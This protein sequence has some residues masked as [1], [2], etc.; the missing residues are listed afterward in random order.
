[1][2]HGVNLLYLMV[3]RPASSLQINWWSRIDLASMT[4]FCG[5]HI[6]PGRKAKNCS[7]VD[8]TNKPKTF[9]YIY[10]SKFKLILDPV[11]NN[12]LAAQ[13]LTFTLLNPYNADDG[14][15]TL[16]KANR[17]TIKRKVKVNYDEASGAIL[18]WLVKE[19]MI[20][21]DVWPDCQRRSSSSC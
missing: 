9:V 4:G 14:W 7:R 16:N 5:S 11:A 13:I 21:L 8:K 6:N 3:D 15:A 18:L 12:V 10:W 20:F 19:K 2:Y 1:M 17:M